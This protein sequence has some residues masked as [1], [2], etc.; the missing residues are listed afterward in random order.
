MNFSKALE[1]MKQGCK[2]RRRKW[3]KAITIYIENGVLWGAGGECSSVIPTISSE[4]MMAND[5][6]EY[7]EKLL[8][9]DEK[10]FIDLY[11]DYHLLMIN[12]IKV[13]ERYLYFLAINP[14]N[15]IIEQC[16]DKFR[17]ERTT[18]KKLE[19]N[20]IYTLEELGL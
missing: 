2:V 10:E 5:W 1:L 13:D 17:Y 18:F 7:K 3:D 12:A 11:T 20:K 9:E 4:W 19:R 15:Y 8:T 6:I 16:V 14:D